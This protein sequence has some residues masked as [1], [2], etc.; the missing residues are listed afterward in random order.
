MINKSWQ[1]FA[2][3]PIYI[4][5]PLTPTLNGLPRSC[6]PILRDTGSDRLPDDEV[7]GSKQWFSRDGRLRGLVVLILASLFVLSM[8]SPRL[9]DHATRSR[10]ESQ[11]GQPAGDSVGN[12]S[13]HATPGAT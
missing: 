1:F 11:P 12:P 4:L 13:R 10:R 2:L 7:R 5:C 6:Q 9:W 8:E 3:H